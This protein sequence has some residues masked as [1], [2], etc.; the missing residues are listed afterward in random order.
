MAAG[1]ARTSRLSCFRSAVTRRQAGRLA[2]GCATAVPSE[3]A[4][5]WQSIGMQSVSSGRGIST[6]PL[7]AAG[8]QLARESPS[9]GAACMHPASIRIP[10]LQS[11]WRGS[12]VCITAA[13]PSL[14]A[15]SCSSVATRPR[16]TCCPASSRL[17]HLHMIQTYSSAPR[18]WYAGHHFCSARQLSAQVNGEY[19]VMRG[20]V[21]SATH[22]RRFSSDARSLSALHSTTALPGVTLM[23][24]ARFW[25]T[26]R[27]RHAGAPCPARWRSPRRPTAPRGQQTAAAPVTA[28]R[29]RPRRPPL[30][31][32]RAQTSARERCC[33]GRS[34][35]SLGPDHRTAAAAS[36]AAAATA[37][38]AVRVTICST[39]RQML[40]SSLIHQAAELGS[41]PC[42]ADVSCIQATFCRGGVTLCAA[43][44]LEPGLHLT[45]PGAID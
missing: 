14:L 21:S 7:P 28:R 18:V 20:G 40:Q 42:S 2:A 4:E 10:A 12:M 37:A 33:C 43:P 6:A 19:D 22:A 30:A 31:A 41:L 29:G 45:A 36:V 1:L 3:C 44:L 27:G 23:F 15:S 8:A 17:L 39:Q 11:R 24:T 34:P 38:V 25:T 16:R 9:A 5:T 26:C 32:A 13:R 35:T